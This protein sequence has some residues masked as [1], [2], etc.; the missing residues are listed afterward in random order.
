MKEEEIIEKKKIKSFFVMKCSRCG[1]EINGVSRKHL[2]H[3]YGMHMFFCSIK[4]PKEDE[5]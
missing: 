3:N 1:A 4:K 5:K 2:K